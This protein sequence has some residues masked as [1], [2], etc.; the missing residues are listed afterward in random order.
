MGGNWAIYADLFGTT[1]YLRMELK[2]DGEKLS[3]TYTGDKLTL[4]TVSG[5]AIHWWP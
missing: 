3:G 4:G 5:G 1:I 2:Q